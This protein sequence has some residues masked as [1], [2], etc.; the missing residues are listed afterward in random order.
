MDNPRITVL[1]GIYNCAPTLAEALDSLLAQT[2]QGFKAVLCDDGSTDGTAALAQSYADRYPGKFILI[3]NKRN[4]GLNYT[5]NHCLEYADTEYCARMDGDDISLPTRLEQEINYLDAHPDIA[6]VSTPVIYF[7]EQGDFKISKGGNTYPN[8]NDLLHA[9]PHIHPTC[10]VRTEVYKE[11]GG[12]SVDTKLLR[13]EDYHLWFKI[14]AK[15]YRGFVM[16]EP[17]HRMRDDRNA[18]ARRTWQNRINEFYVRKI[19]YAMLS[20]PYYKRIWM[21]RPILVGLLPNA[22]YKFLHRL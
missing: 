18:V 21:L 4:M 11:V 22:A 17:L 3:R 6:I 20:I 14:Y 9:T 2:Y 10:M 8:K 13:V 12:Y 7:D 1:M 5:L 15:G 19:G 16:P